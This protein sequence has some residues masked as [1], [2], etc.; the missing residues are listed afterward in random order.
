MLWMSANVY[1]LHKMNFEQGSEATRHCEQ[2][3][4]QVVIAAKLHEQF[5]SCKAVP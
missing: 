5:P 3:W 1:H 4:D 2:H